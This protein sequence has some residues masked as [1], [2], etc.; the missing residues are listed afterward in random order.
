[1][2]LAFFDIFVTVERHAVR[3]CLALAEQASFFINKYRPATA[4]SIRC[5]F[6]PCVVWSGRTYIY[7]SYPSPSTQYVVA[8]SRESLFIEVC[9]V[10]FSGRWCLFGCSSHNHGGSCLAQPLFFCVF[11]WVFDEDRSAIDAQFPTRQRSFGY[12]FKHCES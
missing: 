10:Y 9:F 2:R 12:F 5:V 11:L 1:M 6:V 7:Q 8:N 4:E 3:P